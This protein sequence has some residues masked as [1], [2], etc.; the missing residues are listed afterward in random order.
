MKYVIIGVLVVITILFVVGCTTKKE[1]NDK[2]DKTVE[3]GELKTLDLFYTNGYA[4]QA[5]VSYKIN[6]DEECT[7]IVKPY[8]KSEEESITVNINNEDIKKIEEILKKYEVGKWNGFSKTDPNV[9]DGD[10]F[11]F[12]VTF[13]DGKSISA[14]GYMM[15]PTNYG[16]VEKEL[17]EIFESLIGE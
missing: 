6:C 11:H 5:D 4:Y 10:S 17:E 7:L 15:Y 16:S 8:L 3:I 12:Y 1:K 14:S 13:K 2:D 9:L